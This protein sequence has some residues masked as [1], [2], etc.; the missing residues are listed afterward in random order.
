MKTNIV[1]DIWPPISYLPKFWF[2]SHRSKCCQP[3]KL[4]DSIKHISRKKWAVKCIFSMLINIEV[5]Y[6]LILSFW[7]CIAKLAQSTQNN[8]FAIFLQYLKDAVK[9]KLDFLPVD[10]HQ[11]FFQIDTNSLGVCDQAC[12]NYPK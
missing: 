9:D 12:P 10:K 3:I 4:Q 2:S 11:R 1:I 6:K 8:K 5:F 7:V